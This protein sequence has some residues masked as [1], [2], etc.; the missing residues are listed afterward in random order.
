VG[1]VVAKGLFN[2]EIREPR[3]NDERLAADFADWRRFCREKGRR[4][5]LPYFFDLSS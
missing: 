5:E 1:F 2:R 3:E 4:F